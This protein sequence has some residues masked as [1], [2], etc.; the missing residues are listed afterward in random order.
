MTVVDVGR[1]V[2]VVLDVGAKPLAF[3]DVE[4]VLSSEREGFL[5][6]RLRR[7]M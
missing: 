7:P 3:H 1:V 4:E 6:G 5:L 2:V